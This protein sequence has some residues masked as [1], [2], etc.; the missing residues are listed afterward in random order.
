MVVTRMKGNLMRF[1]L[2]SLLLVLLATI[3]RAEDL[4]PYEAFQLWAGC[5][6]VDLF[7]YLQK[8][9]T[10]IN[11]TQEAIEIAVRS[12]LRSARLY[13]ELAGA[14]TLSVTVHV[15]DVAYNIQVELRKTLSDWAHS[16]R[17]GFGTTWKSVS[18]GTHGNDT[19]IL[20]SLSQHIDKFLDE[21][22]RVNADTC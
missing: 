2:V 6:P 17:V 20:S 9:E 19:N 5:Q 3:S 22:L 18:T 11:L 14:T 1:F 16:E 8:H 7:V 13:D 12:R 21:Y 4:D 10:E 15:V